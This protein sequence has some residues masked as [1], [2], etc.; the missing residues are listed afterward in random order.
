MSDDLRAELSELARLFQTHVAWQRELGAAELP[1]T[2]SRAAPELAPAPPAATPAS[3]S[4][5]PA[6]P[7]PPSAPPAVVAPAVVAPAVVAPSSPALLDVDPP[8][9]QGDPPQGRA[10]RTAALTVIQREV[11]GCS[12]CKLAQRRTQTVF[13]RGN[14]EARLVF[15]GEGPGEQEDKQGMPFVGPAGQLLDKIIVAMNLAPD[16]VYVCNVVK[17]RPPGNRT[18]E[19]DE[20]AACTPFLL[21]QLGVVRPEVIV[22]LGRT[23]TGFLLGSNAPMSRLRGQW[24]TY[25]GIALLPTW[26]PSYLLREPAHKGE[27]WSDM[28]LVM[29]RLGLTPPGARG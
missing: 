27:T 7:P 11:A 5:P 1:R 29:Q 18:P 24:H 26:H 19:P 21:R 10:E 16:A 4:P 12:A 9:A 28:K 6:T 14:P 22:T 25:Q 13:A 17:C 2:S 8:V 20:V 15:I 3:A 23:A